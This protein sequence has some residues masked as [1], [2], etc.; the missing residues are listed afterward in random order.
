MKWAGYLVTPLILSAF[1]V[2][3]YLLY[4]DHSAVCELCYRHL[5][6]ETAYSIRLSQGETV[7]VCCARCG[8]HFEMGRTDLSGSEV[9]DYNSRRRFDAADAFYVENSS[10][11]PCATESPVRKD[12]SG[13]QYSLDWDRCLPSL[14]AFQS[15]EEALS[16]QRQKGGV[17]K[18]YHEL[19][20][21]H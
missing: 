13:R 18:N 5:H 1:C 12:Q 21:N 20:Q 7:D 2:A 8:L 14:V 4:F 9:A 17:I 15:K 16:F 11:H 19:H 10:V 3:G 6:E